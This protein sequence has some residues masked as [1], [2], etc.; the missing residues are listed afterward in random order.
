MAALGFHLYKD[1]AGQFRWYFEAENG[2]KMADSGE[3]YVNKQDC[4][5][6]MVKIMNTTTQTPWFDH[7]K[8]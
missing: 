4:F 8:A 2:K 3:G 1:N 6:G 7:T 5:N